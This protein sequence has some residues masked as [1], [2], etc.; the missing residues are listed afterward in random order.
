MS[1]DAG[2]DRIVTHEG[3]GYTGG[4]R[5]RRESD[6]L[7]Q[8]EGPPFAP[9]AGVPVCRRRAAVIERAARGLDAYNVELCG[10]GR[11]ADRSIAYR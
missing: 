9:A 11:P 5:G 7:T 6:V 3:E 8:T 4:N 2:G 1:R 10:P